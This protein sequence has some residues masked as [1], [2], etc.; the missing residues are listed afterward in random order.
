[1]SIVSKKCKGRLNSTIY[2]NIKLFDCERRDV[3]LVREDKIKD[4]ISVAGKIVVDKDYA[5]TSANLR[6]WKEHKLIE[7]IKKRFSM[8]SHYPKP[9][10]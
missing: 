10:E 6:R 1:M 5:D 9:K 4:N 7:G 8:C 3:K 2:N